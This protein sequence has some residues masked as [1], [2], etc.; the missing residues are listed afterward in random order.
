[1]KKIIIALLCVTM[2]L[3][4]TTV[5][6]SAEQ[7]EEM[8]AYV[9]GIHYGEATVD[10]EKDVSY[11]AEPTIGSYVHTAGATYEEGKETSFDAY[12][13][14]DDYSFYGYIE[15]TDY[16]PVTYATEGWKTD[17][18]QLYFIFTADHSA[19]ISEVR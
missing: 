7:T 11:P 1:M 18:V 9:G 19:N 17:C 12:L 16:S 13:L 5:F 6:A 8:K 10:G 15:V 3:S 14:W 2:V 4:L